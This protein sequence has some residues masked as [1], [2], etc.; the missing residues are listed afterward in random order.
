MLCSCFDVCVQFIALAATSQPTLDHSMNLTWH[1]RQGVPTPELPYTMI[2]RAYL[3]AAEHR[4]LGS[5][6]GAHEGGQGQRGDSGD[7]HL[8]LEIDGLE[9]RPVCVWMRRSGSD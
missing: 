8:D 1:R 5:G 3:G 2:T 9:G 7:L 6:G 4:S